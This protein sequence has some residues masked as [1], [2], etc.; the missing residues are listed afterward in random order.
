MG[1]IEQP[2][3]PTWLPPSRSSGFHRTQGWLGRRV[4][5]VRCEER[6]ILAATRVRTPTVLP[7]TSRNTDYTIP[8]NFSY[9]KLL[10][11]SI[12]I[13]NILSMNKRNI[14]ILHITKYKFHR[15]GVLCDRVVSHMYCKFQLNQKHVP[16][17]TCD[18]LPGIIRLP[19]IVSD[20]VFKT[21]RTHT[22]AVI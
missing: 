6:K 20:K 18:S 8:V 5:T 10:F 2:N 1:L 4:N 3:F 16:K 15:L 22:E 19:Q 9:T 7:V 14:Q 13:L 21:D 17:C 11:I 12:N